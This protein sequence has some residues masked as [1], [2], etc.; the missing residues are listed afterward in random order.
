M[1]LLMGEVHWTM[2]RLQYFWFLIGRTCVEDIIQ[3]QSEMV[4]QRGSECS[5]WSGTHTL[6]R[7]WFRVSDNLRFFRINYPGEQYKVSVFLFIRSSCQSCH[8]LIDFHCLLVCGCV[9]THMPIYVCWRGQLMG[10]KRKPRPWRCGTRWRLT[11]TYK[12]GKAA[13]C[14]FQSFCHQSVNNYH[15]KLGAIEDHWRC[16][17]YH[18]GSFCWWGNTWD[19]ERRQFWQR[20]AQ[21]SEVTRSI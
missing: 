1:L 4:T 14:Y 5:W 18:Q 2:Q 15:D 12:R 9:C 11:H 10:N 8:S 17:D 21:L 16:P 3:Q 13:A 19:V 7:T 6:Y 20:R